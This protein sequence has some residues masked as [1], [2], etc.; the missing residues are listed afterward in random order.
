VH[1]AALACVVGEDVR[2]GGGAHFCCV[3]MF[4]RQPT[5]PPAGVWNI[6]RDYP[7]ILIVLIYFRRVGWDSGIAKWDWLFAF[8]G[9]FDCLIS[10]S[11]AKKRKTAPQTFEIRHFFH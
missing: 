8:F 10:I 11:G 9:R 5:P 4:K 3:S 1:C 6:Y 7:G 2:V